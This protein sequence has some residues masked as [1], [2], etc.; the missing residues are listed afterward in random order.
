MDFRPLRTSRKTRFQASASWKALGI[1]CV[2]VLTAC[3]KGGGGSSAGAGANSQPSFSYATNPAYYVLG[4]AITANTLNIS[5]AATSYSISPSLPTGLSFST[6]TGTISGTPTASS[7]AA[8]Y[9]VTGHN[10]SGS[11]F[12]SVTIGTD[13]VGTISYGS[14]SFETGTSVGTVTPTVSS[15]SVTSCTISPALPAGLSFNTSTCAITGTPTS[16]TPISANWTIT[17]Y[18]GSP[19]SVQG[20]AINPLITVTPDG[21]SVTYPSGG[22]LNLLEGISVGTIT[23][24]V[25]NGPV[26]SCSVSPALPAGLT[27]NTSNCDI[28]GAPTTTLTQPSYQVT[29]SNVHGNNPYTFTITITNPVPAITYA[30]NTQTDTY[31]SPSTAM[32]PTNTGGEITNCTASSLPAGLSLNTTTCQISGTPTAISGAT[33]YSITPYNGGIPGTP[34]TVTLTVNDALPA[35]SFAGSPYTF[36]DNTAITAI[37]A[38]RTAGSTVT[39]CAVAPALPTGLSVTATGGTCQLSG[40]PTAVSAATSYTIT[41]SN[42]AGAGTPTAITIQ[43]N[44]QAPHITFGG[45]P[46]N[47]TLN[48]SVGA[49]IISTNSAGGNMTTCT[50]SPALPG[51]LSIAVVTSA[52]GTN[53]DCQIT[54]T[55]NLVS[56][57]RTTTSPRPTPLEAP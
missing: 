43:V 49:G 22:A 41:P 2:F 3:G 54:G 9:T 5:N 36:T 37:N 6:T 32:T 30:P 29:P 38:T 42:T 48:S 56:Q 13:D 35:V 16:T 24:T 55:P 11:N 46:F 19:A 14:L 27:L 8:T 51:G 23:A 12:A 26:T 17:P 28:T 50:S 40:T 10:S 7:G 20:G 21:P 34:V 1:L 47:F 45:S 18:Y 44:E 25:S 39:G 31:G 15:G 57:R 53:N 52:P 33:G 4:S